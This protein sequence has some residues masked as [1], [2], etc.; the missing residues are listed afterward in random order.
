MSSVLCQRQRKSTRKGEN[1]GQVLLAQLHVR[2]LNI[3]SVKCCDQRTKTEEA[4]TSLYFTRTISRH[5]GSNANFRFYF[6]WL[7]TWR[8]TLLHSPQQSLYLFCSKKHLACQ[9]GSRQGLLLF[10]RPIIQ[11][12]S[13]ACLL[14]MADVSCFCLVC[15]HPRK[16]LC[17]KH[18]TE[19]AFPS[20]G[21]NKKGC[22]K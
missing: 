15:H 13:C 5:G 17:K 4:T 10:F 21:S 1:E 7:T 19:H 16:R 12:P 22:S 6:P 20:F 18:D 14:T 3:L 8:K 9:L 2:M 11:I